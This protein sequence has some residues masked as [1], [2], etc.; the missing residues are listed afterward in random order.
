VAAAVLLG[1][2]TAVVAAVTSPV[3]AEGERAAAAIPEPPSTATEWL[4]GAPAVVLLHRGEVWPMDPP[5]R[6]ESVMQVTR[7]VRILDE[8]GA[9]Q[10]G[11]A[12]IPT[13]PALRLAWFEGSTTTRDGE[14]I[15]LP[16]DAIF[17]GQRE[18]L[19][20]V[21]TAVF[22]KV[23][24]GATL[25]YRYELRYATRVDID[26]WFFQEEIPVLHSECYGRRSRTL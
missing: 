22:T 26:P 16:T 19:G 11:V 8:M 10:Y 9:V 24:V 21:M 12:V 25:E 17:H 4:N 13:G 5:G 14:V 6:A 1:V 2:G 7:R 23:G 20:D 3:V 18:G 15:A